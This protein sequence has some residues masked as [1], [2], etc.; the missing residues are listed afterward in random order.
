MICHSCNHEFSCFKESFTKI[1]T[2]GY[3]VRGECPGC[4]KWIKWV[5]YKDSVLVKKA[6][7]LYREEICQEEE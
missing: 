5:P 3:H 6:I 2:G 4:G 1:A 7:E